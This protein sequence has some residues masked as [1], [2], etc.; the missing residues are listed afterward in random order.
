MGH[1][2]SKQKGEVIRGGDRGQHED[3]VEEEWGA[4]GFA[5]SEG[6]ER[7]QRK[8]ILRGGKMHHYLLKRAKKTRDP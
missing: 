3:V 4:G 8:E 2:E 5:S 1:S 6:A 7:G